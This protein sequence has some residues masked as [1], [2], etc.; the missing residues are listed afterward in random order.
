MIIIFF[1]N[2]SIS[3]D[4]DSTDGQTSKKTKNAFISVKQQKT[5]STRQ[6]SESFPMTSNTNCLTRATRQHMFGEIKDFNKEALCPMRE[7]I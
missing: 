7:A 3:L 1:S 4:F 5:E 2:F 6:F